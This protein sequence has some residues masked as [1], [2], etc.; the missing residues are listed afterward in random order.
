MTP[1]DPSRWSRLRDLLADAHELA[2]EDRQAWLTTATDDAALRT[3]VMDML[4]ATEAAQSDGFLSAPAA[5]TS[6]ALFADDADPYIGRRVGPW[7]LTSSLGEGGMGVVYRAERADVDFEQQAALK[8]VG[9]GLAP[10]ALVERFR[11]ERRILARLEHP[12]IARLLDG[13]VSEDGQPYFAMELVDGVPLTEYAETH[14]LDVRQRLRLMLDVCAAVA[15][16]HRNLVVHR[17]LKPSNILVAE[18]ADCQ[19]VVRLLDFGIATV[20]EEDEE[21]PFRTRTG[22]LMTPAYAAPEQVRGEPVTTATDVYALG[23]VLF[24]LLAGQRPYDLEPG[25]TPTVIERTVCDTVPPPPSD[26]APSARASQIRGDLDT[27]VLKALEKEPTR[28]YASAEALAT[29]IERHLSGLPVSARRATVGYRVGS[30][31]RRHPV[32]VGLT[33]L[34]VAALLLGMAGTTWQARVASAERDRAQL[35]TAKAE[36]IRDYVINLFSA[37]NPDSALG[38][39]VT[40]REALDLGAS[41][42]ATELA[43]QP[44]VRADLELAIAQLY[45]RLAEYD[46]ARE[47]ASSAIALREDHLGP[48]HPETATARRELAMLLIETGDYADS[49]EAGERAYTDHRQA[50]GPEDPET[51][52][53]LSAFGMALSELGDWEEAETAFTELADRYRVVGDSVALSEALM[54]LGSSQL[55]Q[56]RF[57]EAEGPFRESMELR[58]ALY[59]TVHS[60]TATVMNSLA[61]AVARG[62]EDLEESE[63][64]LVEALDVRRQLY[65]D[66]HP[67]VAQML[68]SLAR[69]YEEKGDLARAEATYDELLPMMQ[70]VL[71]PE[72]PYTGLVLINYG[73]LLRQRGRPADGESFVRQGHAIDRATHGPDHPLAAESEVRLAHILVALG[74]N[75][76]AEPLLTH[77][78]PILEEAYG[79]DASPVQGAY[80]VRDA[81]QE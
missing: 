33:T 50:L 80:E 71:G 6:A 78:I 77:A 67:E 21:S 81:M 75:A 19:P 76:E 16:A 42:V 17:D 36:E 4:Q 5:E 13:G 70:S 10:R 7:Q 30:F 58:R 14:Q 3:E 38:R 39:D 79:P 1:P 56:Q 51:L 64:L 52:T 72:H 53:S 27:I 55:R 43:D 60:S 32:G 15:Y 20:L 65:G 40:V 73:N 49:R 2:P 23:V 74:R 66:Q 37:A 47:H 26:Q 61:I 11:Q 68:N 24:E 28:R 34:A 57:E 41:R 9:R 46:P 25:T 29:D 35:E 48:Q 8:L 22:T 54:N 44:V 69:L 62:R 59:G 45:R 12:G 63:A 18:D 31:V